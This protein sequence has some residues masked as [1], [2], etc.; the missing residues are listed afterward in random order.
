MYALRDSLHLQYYKKG[1]RLSVCFSLRRVSPEH[2]VYRV[3]ADFRFIMVLNY[4]QL[5][6]PS[7]AYVRV[8]MHCG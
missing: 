3:D 6:F 5:F 4:F 7:L 1:K 2:L 8:C